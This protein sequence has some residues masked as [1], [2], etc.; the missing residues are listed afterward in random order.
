[1]TIILTWELVDA[2]KQYLLAGVRFNNNGKLYYYLA[3][4]SININEVVATKNE[5]GEAEVIVDEL[6]LLYEDQ[7]PLPLNK[8]GRVYKK[9]NFYS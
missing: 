2:T 8:L 1:M 9:K 7:L 5:N 6:L 4:P 3:D